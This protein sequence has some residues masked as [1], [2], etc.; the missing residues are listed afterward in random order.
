MEKGKMICMRL[1]SIQKI[2]VLIGLVQGCPDLNMM[3]LIWI[4]ILMN[5]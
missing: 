1:E 4:L 2:A 3:I 5:Y